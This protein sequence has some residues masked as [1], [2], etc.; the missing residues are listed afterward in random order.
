M[1]HFMFLFTPPPF[2]DIL[3]IPQV[4]DRLYMFDSLVISESVT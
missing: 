1:K 2:P 4:E 3:H